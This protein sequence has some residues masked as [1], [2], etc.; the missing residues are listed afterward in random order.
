MKKIVTWGHDQIHKDADE[1]DQAKCQEYNAKDT[2]DG[3][4]FRIHPMQHKPCTLEAN[5]Q[6]SQRK[7]DGA[8]IQAW[9]NQNEI[10]V[11]EDK[12]RQ[13]DDVMD[14]LAGLPDK[15]FQTNV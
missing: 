12:N 9:K 6:K 7:N 5:Y 4:H 14:L 15:L 11:N 3:T 8:D 2:R 10:R 1:T 13:Q